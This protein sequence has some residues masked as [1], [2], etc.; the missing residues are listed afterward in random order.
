[1]PA[2]V[3]G[4]RM[5]HDGGTV[6]ERPADHG[7]GGVVHDQRHA[8]L[9]PDRGH[10]ADREHGELRVGQRLG[11]VGAGAVV[12][13][14]P[15]GL[16]VGRIG[17]AHG[18]AHGRQR[19]GEQV[20]GAAIEVGGADHV[21][22]GPAQVLQRH[23]RGGL[24]GAD[25]QRRNAAFERR[26]PLLQRITGGIHDARIDVAELLQPEQV[27][28]MLRVAELVGRGLHDRH[29]HGACGTIV[30]RTGVQDQRLG[31]LARCNHL[32]SPYSRVANETAGI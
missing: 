11:I 31:I 30:A 32:L 5:D 6:I 23:R 2:D 8:E 21:V 1:M 14:P 27:R 16:G 18:D 4:G 25:G 9:A 28:R 26:H 22:A 7:R 10:L 12:G 19:V 17:E 29:C 13:R 15:E 20:P 24:A 3:L